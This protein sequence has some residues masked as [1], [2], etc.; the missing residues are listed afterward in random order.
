MVEQFC[1]ANVQIQLPLVQ[2]FEGASQVVQSVIYEIQIQTLETIFTLSAE[3]I[4]RARRPGKP[5]GEIRWHGWQ[6][7]RVKLADR[8]VKVKPRLWH[9]TEGE[10]KI[11]AYEKQRQDRGLEQHM[12][13]R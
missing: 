10:V 12:L 4:A 2:L 9:K 6:H 7:G 1:Q 11:P 8:A 3:Q 13:G 5:S